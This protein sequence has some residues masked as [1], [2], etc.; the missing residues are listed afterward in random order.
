MSKRG[1]SK[2]YKVEYQKYKDVPEDKDERLDYIY[3][4]L[5]VTKNDLIEIL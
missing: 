2:D 4:K 1:K 3:K 5:K